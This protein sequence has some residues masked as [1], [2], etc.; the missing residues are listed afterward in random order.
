[1]KYII[2]IF[3]VSVN[4]IFSQVLP[5]GQKDNYDLPESR[6]ENPVYAGIG[7]KESNLINDWGVET[8]LS[9][10]AYL[11]KNFAIDV[12]YYY[13]FTNNIKLIPDRPEFL[14]LD[15]YGLR[16]NPILP[17]SDYVKLRGMGG[18]YLA[19]SSYSENI[20]FDQN[21]DLQ[22]D[23][24]F[25]GELGGGIDIKVYTPIVVTLETNYRFA[26]GVD[27]KYIINKNLSGVNLGIIIKVEL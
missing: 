19:H 27:F 1:M 21:R 20:N 5:G 11:H 12:H 4:L 18:L 8:G 24:F 10:G 22:G 3:I 7:I 2:F 16:L 26:S 25:F 9:V 13:L 15:Y 14:R 23:W 17:I 6:R